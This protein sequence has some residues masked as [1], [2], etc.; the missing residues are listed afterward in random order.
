MEH[1]KLLLGQL[2]RIQ[3]VTQKN[4]YALCN[5]YQHVHAFKQRKDIQG[6]HE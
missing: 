5:F 4:I 2:D 3:K 1:V 6:T